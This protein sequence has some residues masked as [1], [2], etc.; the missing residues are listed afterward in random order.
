VTPPSSAAPAEAYRCRLDALH[1]ALGIDP[2]MCARRGLVL[3][4]EATLLAPVGLGTDGRDKLLTPAAAAAWL[5]LRA[6]A[7]SD[8]IELLLISAFR[9]AD[10]QAALIRRKLAA[11][12]PI[13]AILEINAPPGYSEHHTGCAADIGVAACEALSDDFERTEAFAWLRRRAGEFDFAM[14]Y[15]RGNAQAFAYEPWHWCY[16]GRA[17]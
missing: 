13:A 2:A 17:D 3:H 14:S 10:Y 9:S 5:A 8:G 7:R 11:G 6:A 4:E 1:A 16:H 15:P 12:Q